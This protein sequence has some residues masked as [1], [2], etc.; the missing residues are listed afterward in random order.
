[1]YMATDDFP[2]L[3]KVPMGNASADEGFNATQWR[4]TGRIPCFFE[5]E[6]LSSW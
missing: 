1:M 6:E 3:L 2:Y 4:P 5:E